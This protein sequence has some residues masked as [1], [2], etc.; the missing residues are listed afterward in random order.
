MNA[1]MTARNNLTKSLYFLLNPA[2]SIRPGH[3]AYLIVGPPTLVGKG[4]N[5]QAIRVMISPWDGEGWLK[6]LPYLI[7]ACMI[8]A[9]LFSTGPLGFWTRSLKSGTQ[10]VAV[11]F[12]EDLPK[13]DPSPEPELAPVPEAPKKPTLA[14]PGGETGTKKK[15]R[16]AP[17][18]KSISP[19]KPVITKE[20]RRKAAI[21]A[22]AR[23]E[24]AELRQA[25]L[26]AARQA[27]AQRAAVLAAARAQAARQAVAARVERE[28]QLA[29]A[30]AEKARR[31]A[32]ERA[33]ENRRR[34]EIAGTLAAMK[35]PDEALADTLAQPALSSA[36]SNPIS[37][38]PFSNADS[39]PNAADALYDDAG[40][41]SGEDKGI[42]GGSAGVGWSL[43]GPAGNRRL[44]SRRLPACPAW[45]GQRALSLSAQIKF[46]VARDGTVKPG[47]IIK[48][49]SGF[50]DIDRLALSTLK[51][52]RFEAAAGEPWGLVTFR[53]LPE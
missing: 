17:I 48:R 43:E 25:Q 15:P 41:G 4:V 44:L 46:Q 3:W 1:R 23:R 10:A 26:R 12:V 30:R 21:L 9:A 51:T 32:E 52:W 53:F 7:V 37:Q 49:T 34:I 16:P 42:A 45:V 39:L 22:Q 38:G 13:T 11:D 31:I 20:A 24:A 35:E 28:R 19:R 29:L 33:A 27:A 47:A 2:L 8:H 5:C 14:M 40:D 36:H 18:K 50:P 6:D